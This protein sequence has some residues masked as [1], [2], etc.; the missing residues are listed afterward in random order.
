MEFMNIEPHL[1][2]EAV[3]RNSLPISMVHFVQD[4]GRCNGRQRT[5]VRE[6]NAG[7]QKEPQHL[8]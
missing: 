8:L 7:L 2:Q 3:R 6:K 4:S 5:E 1:G